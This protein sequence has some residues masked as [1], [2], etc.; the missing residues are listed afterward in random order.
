MELLS[1]G[2]SSKLLREAGLPRRDGVRSTVTVV[3]IL[4]DDIV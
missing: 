4:F 1:K 3:D 2:S